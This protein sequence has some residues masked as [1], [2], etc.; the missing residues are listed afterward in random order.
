M[1]IKIARATSVSNS[2]FRVVCGE[3]MLDN[4]IVSHREALF[5]LVKAG[6]AV[7]SFADS[8]YTL[9]KGD[10]YFVS[11]N[12]KYK[13]S[14]YS[15]AAIDVITL[16]FANPA[17]VTQDY[18]PQSIIRALINGNCKPF[19]LIKPEDKDYSEIVE[20]LRQIKKAESEKYEYFQLKVYS[21]MY[22][23]FYMLFADGY[24]TI[25]D[26]ENKS[27]KY[28]A[29]V[30]V[31]NYIDEHYTESISLDEVAGQTG[32]S[33]YYVSHL[34][35]ELMN[36]TFVGYVNELRLNRAAMLLVT[37]DKPIIEIA[38]ISGFNNLSNFNRA[39][40]MHFGKTPS[41]YRKA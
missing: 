5:G 38:S 15:D 10:F 29:L 20:N 32:I 18:M 22:D 14:D 2:A 12:A 37:T 17:A 34:F 11:P 39:F 8:T 13:F 7:V 3:M 23:V 1:S 35:K 33:R 24:V 21:D 16:N 40:K 27:K 6:S 25:N 28:R 41:A 4:S 26:V 9:R 30:R 19:A 36:T 31:T